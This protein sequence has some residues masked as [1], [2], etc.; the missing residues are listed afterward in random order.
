M[1]RITIILLLISSYVFGAQPNSELSTYLDGLLQEAKSSDA[2]FV[3][4]SVKRGEE[5]FTS[6]HIGKKGE[7]ISCTSCHNSDLTKMGKNISTNKSIEPLAPSINPQRLTNVNDVRKW[8]RR[9]FKDVYLQEGSA[10]QKGDVLVYIL[11]K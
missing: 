2:N 8:L 5:I 9:N 7:M 4:F 3:G 1:K 11:S 10:Q 6:K